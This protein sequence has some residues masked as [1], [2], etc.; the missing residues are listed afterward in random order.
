MITLYADSLNPSS[1][2]DTEVTLATEL[3]SITLSVIDSLLFSKQ[4]YTNNSPLFESLILRC[5]TPPGQ[6]GETLIAG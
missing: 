6:S 3:I 1:C 4:L 2:F 5:T